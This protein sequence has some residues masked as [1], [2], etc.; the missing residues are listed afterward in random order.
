MNSSFLLGRLK[1]IE[2][3]DSRLQQALEAEQQARWLRVCCLK[4][5]YLLVE[6]WYGDMVT[7]MNGDF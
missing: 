6:W 4:F 2:A 3:A 7:S 5:Q 1:K